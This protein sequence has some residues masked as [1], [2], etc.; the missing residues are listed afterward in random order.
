M[1]VLLRAIMRRAGVSPWVATATALSVVVFGA[2][3]NNILSSFQMTFTGALALGL[4]HMLLADHRG[5]FDW[6]D[7]L[8]LLAGLG[9]LMCSGVGIAMAVGVG[10]AV[11]IRR[12]WRMAAAHV[13]PLAAAYLVW[14]AV[15][16]P[17]NR[18]NPGQVSTAGVVEG[19]LRWFG[20]AWWGAFQGLGRSGVVALCLV[21]LLVA[22]GA[23][24]WLSPPSGGRRRYAMPAGAAVAGLSFLFLTAAGRWWLPWNSPT[25][26]RYVYLAVA[27]GLPAV[28]VAAN[29]L[30]QRWLWT[31][32]V[33]LLLVVAGVPA[34]L[35]LAEDPILVALGTNDRQI[36][37]LA[38]E[39][40]LA[41]QVDPSGRPVLWSDG[42]V[43]DVTVSWLLDAH[44]SGKLPAPSTSTQG[45]RDFVGLALAL[46]PITERGS[47]GTCAVHEDAVDISPHAGQVLWV[48]GALVKVTQLDDHG[49]KLAQLWVDQRFVHGLDVQVD[50][51]HLR[52][53]SASKGESF[54]LCT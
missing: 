10:V 11:L 23:I 24:A 3:S 39:L 27:L 9:A 30:I 48:D 32:P 38:P 35:R 7:A 19:L 6:R 40:P 42:L 41:R 21:V 5:P 25:A 17:S 15:E 34:N 20:R 51:L 18:L 44:T 29:T 46:S 26:S 14:W 33:V 54:E 16:R 1:V 2:G 22:G 36:V 4:A 53:A 31:A 37:V 47:T 45:D 12:G 43:S 49:Q 52:L 13:A 28:A 8:G 50:G